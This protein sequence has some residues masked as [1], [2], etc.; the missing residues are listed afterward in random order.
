MTLNFVARAQKGSQEYNNLLNQT[1]GS[2][3]FGVK[4]ALIDTTNYHNFTITMPRTRMQSVVNGDDANI[5]TV[6]CGVTALVPTDGVT[7]IISM[8]A[9]TT[10]DMI[11]G[12]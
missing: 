10:Q 1:E 8:A 11:L 12:L 7:P 2:A 3:V 4:G 6:N 5:V 9:T